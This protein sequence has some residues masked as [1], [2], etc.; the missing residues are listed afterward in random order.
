MNAIML[1]LVMVVIYKEVIKIFNVLSLFDGISVGQVALNRAGIYYDNYYSSEIKKSAIRVTNFH[2]PNTIQLGDVT[3]LDVSILPKIDLLLG[4]SPCQTISRANHKKGIYD[5]KSELFFEFLRIFRSIKPKYFLF[6]NVFGHK[7]SIDS[8]TFYLGVS[9]LRINSNLVS[10]QNRD[11]LYWT[12]IPVSNLPED[13]HISFQDYKETN[14]D[15]LKD[16]VVKRTPSRIKMWESKCP[17]VTY[18]E[19]INCLTCKQDR[20]N[21]SGLVE[22]G[23]FCRYLTVSECEI[24]Q[25][26]PVGYT[27]ILSRSQSY[28]VLG[29]CWTADVISHIFSFFKR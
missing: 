13:K 18:R 29:D 20:W 19:K 5:G 8:I 12:N 28:D 17:N 1:S 21:N 9:P 4:G 25:N 16:Y 14:C 24:A 15:I 22:Y 3:K 7:E 11:R 2:F 10:Y 26:L 23:D 27:K 6:E